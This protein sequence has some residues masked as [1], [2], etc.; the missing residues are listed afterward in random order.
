MPVRACKSRSWSAAKS[1]R[2]TCGVAFQRGPSTAPLT[3]VRQPHGCSGVWLSA[4][5]HF[6]IYHMPKS[7][8]SLGGV[9]YTSHSGSSLSPPQWLQQAP[10]RPI[11]KNVIDWHVACRR[12]VGCRPI[13]VVQVEQSMCT[14]GPRHAPVFLPIANPSFKPCT[15]TLLCAVCGL[16][17]QPR[18]GKEHGP[19]RA[20]ACKSFQTDAA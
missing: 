20:R 8:L 16:L 6:A 5:K 11:R 2:A 13:D 19:Q 1:G 7:H 18:W 10:C 17:G 9:F 4:G 15:T 14:N 12:D 3:P